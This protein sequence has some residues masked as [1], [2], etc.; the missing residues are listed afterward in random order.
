[1]PE[2][3]REQALLSK[4]QVSQAW[5]WEQQ[6][7]LESKAHLEPSALLAAWSSLAAQVLPRRAVAQAS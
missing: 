2:L 4:Q 3:V 6:V 5:S 7:F 1:M